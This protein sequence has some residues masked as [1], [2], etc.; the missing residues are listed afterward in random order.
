MRK[1]QAARSLPI[2][3]YFL[4][5]NSSKTLELTRIVQ[6]RYLIQTSTS[7]DITSKVSDHTVYVSPINYNFKNIIL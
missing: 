1:G 7:V 4:N 5:S 3:S 2:C 6:P